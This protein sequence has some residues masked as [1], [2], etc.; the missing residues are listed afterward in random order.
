[1]PILDHP[2]QLNAQNLVFEASVLL[3]IAL[4]SQEFVMIYL[5][6]SCIHVTAMHAVVDVSPAYLQ[7]WV[8]RFLPSGQAMCWWLSSY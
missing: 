1:M 8:L 2:K 4:H 3:R 7:G 5:F 6:P